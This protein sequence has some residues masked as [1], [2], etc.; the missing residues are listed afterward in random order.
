M[1]EFHWDIEVC[2]NSSTIAVRVTVDGRLAKL[3]RKT[4]ALNEE[5]MW[6]F[7]TPATWP[8]E[9]TGDER[10]DHKT[11]GLVCGTYE[12]GQS[13]LS[14]CRQAGVK[15]QSTNF[16]VPL[17]NGQ[18]LEVEDNYGNRLNDYT[19]QELRLVRRDLPDLSTIMRLFNLGFDEIGSEQVDRPS[20][21]LAAQPL[22]P[23]H[24]QPA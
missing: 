6:V 10:F 24:K 18:N 5:R 8:D 3:S 15:V 11:A 14:L 2:I 1:K 22:T 21:E 9:A 4:Q 23:R 19:K 7:K 13:F 16:F 17:S 20:A 12:E